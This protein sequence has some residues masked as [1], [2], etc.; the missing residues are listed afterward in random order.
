MR[1]NKMMRLASA[2]LI[3]V[4]LTTCA[5]SGTFAKY[6]T[7]GTGTDS[8]TVAKWG[9]KITANGATFANTYAT[10][11]ESV[12]GTIANSVIGGSSAKVIAPGT[13]GTM[14]AATIS[15]TP[16]VAVK[17]TYKATVTLTGW[18][19]NT[20]TYYCPLEI[21]VGTGEDAHT[22][23][24]TSY[25]SAAKFKEAIETAINGYSDE[26]APN[27]NLGTITVPVSWKWAFEGNDDV[28]DTALADL[29]TAPTIKIEVQVTVTQID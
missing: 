6:T 26:Y 2:L 15:G 9:V 27:T 14:V 1:K 3:A 7:T 11:D 10:N 4:L 29:E 12:V 19:V 24:G 25:E 23:K 18:T 17:V 8:A 16:E 28:K 21:T 20:D 5:I 13:S 22:Y